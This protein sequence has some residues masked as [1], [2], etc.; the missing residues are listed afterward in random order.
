MS[1]FQ[2]GQS[3]NPAG[4]PKGSRGRATI[5]AQAI[6][7]RDVEAV[8]ERIVKA[9]LDGDL[10]AGRLVLERAV[11]P[12]KERPLTVDLPPEMRTA[13]QLSQAAESV[14]R[15]VAEG[16]LLPGEGQAL[17][18][19]IELRRKALET[20]ELAQRVAALEAQETKR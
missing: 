3:G 7:D 15:A 2:P 19:M 4:R 9:A 8:T 20:E 12:M 11:P 18:A 6:L 1:Q 14:F 16:D 10:T 5:L 17:M 13:E